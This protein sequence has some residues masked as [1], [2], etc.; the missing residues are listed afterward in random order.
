MLRVDKLD[1]QIVALLLEDSRSGYGRIG[2]RVGLSAPAVKR[3]VDKLRT[4]GVITGFTIGVDPAVLGTDTEAFVEIFCTGRTAPDEIA[5]S[6]R[7]HPEVAAAYT[8]TGDANAMLHLRTRDTAHLEEVL[9][10]IRGEPNIVQTK[11]AIVLSRL[12]DRPPHGTRR[13][14]QA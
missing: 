1:E 13:P 14:G 8:I 9:E 11:T 6:V 3:R 12:F 7:R 5:R 2:A 4:T 10:R